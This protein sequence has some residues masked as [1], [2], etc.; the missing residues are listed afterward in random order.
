VTDD[1]VEKA[2]EREL[3]RG[4]RKFAELRS[5]VFDPE[6]AVWMNGPI[7]RRRSLDRALQRMR[8]A[9]KISLHGDPPRWWHWEET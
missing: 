9:G 8:N 1:E 7:A 3:R 2:I 4:P 6:R 5:F